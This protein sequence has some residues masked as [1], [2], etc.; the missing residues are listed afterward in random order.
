MATVRPMKNIAVLEGLRGWLAVWV[1]L[2]HITLYCAISNTSVRDHVAK[3][4]IDFLTNGRLAVW[5]FMVL[6]GFVNW[7]LLDMKREP[8]LVYI[9]RR[10]LRLY[11]LYALLFALSVWINVY[12][13]DSLARISWANDSWVETQRLVT[14]QAFDHLGPNLLT[15]AVMLHGLVPGFWWPNAT[16][17]FLGVDWSISTEWQFYLLAPLIFYF[18]RTGRAI[19]LLGVVAILSLWCNW[20][21]YLVKYF[22]NGNPSLLVFKFY[23]FYVGVVSYQFYKRVNSGK[24][25]TGW[26]TAHYFLAGGM[27]TYLATYEPVLVWWG[28]I[29]G[30]VLLRRLFAQ[31]RWLEWLAVPFTHPWAQHLGRI[32][33][34]IYLFHWLAIMLLIRVLVDVAPGISSGHAAWLLF[35]GV[36]ALTVAAAHLLYSV[37]ERPFIRLG[38]R[39]FDEP[40]CDPE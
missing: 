8:A 20:N 16:S 31:D 24:N 23:F 3:Q 15:H 1:M 36:T 14:Q 40:T 21:H 17:A 7:Y 5:L 30:L 2:S 39:L 6:S 9:T 18:C 37:I 19:V 29:L 26:T 38:K 34:S 10:F 22:E 4:Y 33:Y 11:P 13:L 35:P 32:S 27:L 28:L 25:E 12:H